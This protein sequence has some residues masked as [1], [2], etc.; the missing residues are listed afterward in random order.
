M[1]PLT[2]QLLLTDVDGSP[3]AEVEDVINTAGDDPRYF[4][5]IP[6]L[7]ALLADESAPGYDRFLALSALAAWGTAAGLRA[8]QVAAET[9]QET[10][11]RGTSVDR[12][13]S[14]DDTFTLLAESVDNGSD[15][16]EARGT[17][18]LWIAAVRALVRI[19]STVFYDWQLRYLLR[20]RTM[21]LVRPEAE[22]ALREG[23]AN[24]ASTKMPFPL[25][26]QLADI[27]SALTKIDDP[28]GVAYGYQIFELDSSRLTMG[29]LV[30]IVSAGDGSASADFADYLATQG[31]E[32]VKELLGGALE[33]RSQGNA[34]GNQA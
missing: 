32:D 17:G 9:P 15:Y 18:D 34:N 25:G 10:P 20:A 13:Y 27:A 16:I 19:A 30:G 5:R 22:A 2:R 4:E 28:A 31:G 29:H 23:L 21:P 1:L 24:L 11:W 6:A 33:D 7:E 8:A 14:V 3:V 26:P 12:R